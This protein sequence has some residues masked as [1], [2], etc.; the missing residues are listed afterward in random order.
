MWLIFEKKKYVSEIKK[1]VSDI[2][3]PMTE[4]MMRRVRK[5]PL[6]K[7]VVWRVGGMEKY[8]LLWIHG[9]PLIYAHEK[10]QTKTIRAE[11]TNKRSRGTDG[12]LKSDPSSFYSPLRFF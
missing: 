4:K 8:H 3:L 5:M 2:E 7:A 12:T 11:S 10:G 6:G 1:N 9:K